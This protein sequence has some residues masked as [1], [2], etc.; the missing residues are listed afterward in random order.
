MIFA[1]A[2]FITVSKDM[3]PNDAVGAQYF[4]RRIQINDFKKAKLY[5]CGLGYGYCWING[6]RVSNDIFASAHSDYMKTVWYDVYDVSHILQ[7]GDNIFSVCCGN[8]FYNENFPSDW[9]HEHAPWRG[10]PKFILRLELDGK[11]V[12]C[13]DEDWKATNGG[14]IVYN[15]LRSGEYH[16]LRV[17][18]E[19]WRSNTFDDTLWTNAQCAIDIPEGRFK[20]NN[21]QPIRECAVYPAKVIR[22][23]GDK[24]IFDIGQNISGYIR[25]RYTG[26]CGDKLIIRYA[27][28]IKNDKLDDRN[29][30]CF[31]PSVPFQE[32]RILCNGKPFCWSPLFTYHGFRYVEIEG[33]RE[34][35]SDEAVTGIFVHQDIRRLTDFSCSDAV[36]N[37]LYGC[38]VMATYSNLF[39]IITDCPTREKLGWINDAGNSAYQ[40]LVNFDAKALIEKFY[41]DILDTMDDAGTITGIAPSPGWGRD[42]GAIAD[43]TLYRIPYLLYRF[44]GEK[45]YLIKNLSVLEKHFY[46]FYKKTDKDFPLGDWNGSY[47]CDT[48]KKLISKLF[49]AEF[50]AVLKKASELAEDKKRIE[51]YDFLEKSVRDQI[52]QLCLDGNGESRYNSIAV[53]SF[54][55]FYEIGDTTTLLNQLCSALE[56]N[57]YKPNYGM[58]A[59]YYLPFVLSRE[60]KVE[61]LYKILKAENSIFAN[62]IRTNATTLWETY[63]DNAKTFSMNHHLFSSMTVWFITDILGI[64]AMAHRVEIA[65]H[66]VQGIDY[67]KGRMYITRKGDIEVEWYK[68]GNKILLKIVCPPNINAYYNEIKLTEGTSIFEISL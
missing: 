15:M 4:R 2:K 50:V 11:T 9:G 65:P 32:D 31:Y 59:M 58:M 12:L 44:T 8:G 38:S 40:M 63:D 35:L 37:Q 57:N 36:L 41:L 17:W 10:V 3:S 5:F 34:E 64:R 19:D 24:Y 53:I 51:E 16:D 21:C 26:K 43:S 20:R 49:C 52:I 67:A 68:Q 39:S 56:K 29:L 14:I 28:N 27:E 23:D 66:Y 60:G 7:S 46:G 6:R 54:L 33:I 22:R 42:I 62:V 48:P 55:L 1:K 30:G 25:F 18:Q 47:D 13:S 61:I 45:K